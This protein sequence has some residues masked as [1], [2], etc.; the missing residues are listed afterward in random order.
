VREERKN[1]SIG[2]KEGRMQNMIPSGRKE[3]RKEAKGGGKSRKDG[4]KE[5]RKSDKE[6][7]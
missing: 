3:E 2:R 6:G 7:L 4:R 1:G 5:R